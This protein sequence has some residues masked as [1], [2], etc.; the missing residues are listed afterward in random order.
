MKIK[1]YREYKGIEEDKFL[2]MNSVA[3]YVE[4]CIV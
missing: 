3:D 2:N 1:V 4:D